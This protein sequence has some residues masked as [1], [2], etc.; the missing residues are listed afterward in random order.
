MLPSNRT[1]PMPGGQVS[2]HPLFWP[3]DPWGD[4]CGAH[5]PHCDGCRAGVRGVGCG[6][7]DGD[8]ANALRCWGTLAK[9]AAPQSYAHSSHRAA[10]FP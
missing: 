4:G 8:T 9:A 6:G 7:R 10:A 2:R 3:P 1:I 5:G